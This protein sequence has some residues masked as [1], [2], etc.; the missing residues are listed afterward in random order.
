MD[1]GTLSGLSAG[2][3]LA[4]ELS[5]VDWPDAANDRRKA[6]DAVCD[7]LIP[8]AIEGYSRDIVNAHGGWRCAPG[9]LNEEKLQAAVKTLNDKRTACAD[10][11]AAG[12]LAANDV[13]CETLLAAPAARL[14]LR[15]EELLVGADERLGRMIDQVQT[16]ISLWT[17][18]ATAN[19]QKFSFALPETPT[20]V[21]HDDKNGWAVSAVFTRLS[22][23]FL[24][25]VGYS[26]EESYEAAAKVDI[27]SPIGAT[28]SSSCRQ[29]SLGAPTS[30]QSELA[31]AEVRW[32][33]PSRKL[34]L[35]P[36]MQ[37]DI[38]ESEWAVRVPVYLVRNQQG[39][40]TTGLALGYTSKDSDVGLAVF[41][42]KEF[43]F[44]D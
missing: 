15:V 14:S 28:G 17:V 40:F 26:H 39:A 3:S 7:N 35:S 23:A 20:Q 12:T 36:R 24:W 4:F 43:A 6:A 32:I 34:A 29:A 22:R 37:F 42:G 5:H 10:K 44:F 21:D 11:K 33:L 38:E 25:S 8:E 19:E 16:P 18:G 2:T 13:V 27:C 31:F 1:V 30:Q 41:V 9:D